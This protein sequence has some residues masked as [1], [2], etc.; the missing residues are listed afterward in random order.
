MESKT[1]LIQKTD[2]ILKNIKRD[3]VQK[4]YSFINYVERFKKLSFV[5]PHNIYLKRKVSPRTC[6]TEKCIF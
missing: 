3:F 1:H 2:D 6:I 4:I 5:I